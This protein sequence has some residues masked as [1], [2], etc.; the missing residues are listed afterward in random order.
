[1]VLTP[2]YLESRGIPYE[3]LPDGVHFTVPGDLNLEYSQVTSLGALQSVGGSL[4]L[5]GTQVTSLGDLQTVGGSLFLNGTPIT[6]LGKLQS[7]GETYVDG[8]G[9]ISLKEAK[10]AFQSYRDRVSALDPEDLPRRLLK[11]THKWQKAIIK[12]SL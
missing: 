8:Q 1:M 6:S 5:Y 3:M 2:A 12:E 10:E 7:V 4:Y 11:A 9:Y